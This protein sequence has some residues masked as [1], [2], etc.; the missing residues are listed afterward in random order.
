MGPGTSGIKLVLQLIQPTGSVAVVSSVRP[1]STIIS[2]LQLGHFICIRTLGRDVS[3]L[4]DIFSRTWH[5]SIG[6]SGGR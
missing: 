5:L 3:G 2:V 6:V 4:S 1:T